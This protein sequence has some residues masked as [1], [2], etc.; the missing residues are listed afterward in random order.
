MWRFKNKDCIFQ[1]I[2][3]K[4]FFISQEPALDSDAEAETFPFGA[5]STGQGV[6]AQ[7]R[8]IVRARSPWV[9]QWK[10][11]ASHITGS[12]PS[13]ALTSKLSFRARLSCLILK[14]YETD[15]I[16][17]RIYWQQL[18]TWTSPESQAHPNCQAKNPT[19]KQW[20]K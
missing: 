17:A 16:I 18:W 11:E 14:G 3:Q 19:D 2:S 9:S 5:T 6:P 20:K 12:T 4:A 1:K 13:M 8:S 10:P 7:A 15:I